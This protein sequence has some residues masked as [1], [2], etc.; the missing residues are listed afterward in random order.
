M[1]KLIVN[2]NCITFFTE[3]LI[4]RPYI[5]AYTIELNL[6]SSKI[7]SEFYLIISAPFISKATAILA[8]VIACKSFTPK[9]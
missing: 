1:T 8:L 6:L 4:P 9:M 3:L 2:E 5:M 7:I